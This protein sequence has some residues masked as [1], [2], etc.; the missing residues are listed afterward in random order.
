MKCQSC[1]QNLTKRSKFCPNCGERVVPRRTRQAPPPS[2]GSFPSGYAAAFVAV[3][4]VLGFLI[5]KLSSGPGTTQM[6]AGGSQRFQT[7]APIPAALRAEVQEIASNFMCPCGGCNDALDVCTCDMKNGSVEV[8]G[9]IA[10]Q[11]QAGVERSQIIANVNQRYGGLKTAVAPKID[12]QKL[13]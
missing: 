9:F 11:L 13:Q 5:F 12:F 4:A 6:V 3:G 2:R 8:K 1:G 10:Q 7:T